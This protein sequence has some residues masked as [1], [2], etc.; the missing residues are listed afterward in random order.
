LHT[1]PLALKIDISGPS[2]VGKTS[3]ARRFAFECRQHF[4]LITVSCS[5]LVH[6]VVGDS[7]RR[8]SELFAAARKVA[9]TLI[10]LENIDIMLGNSSAKE[11][12][13]VA[14]NNDEKGDQGI[15]AEFTF[16]RSRTSDK[17][18]DRFLSAFL[19]EMDGI[20]SSSHSDK[21]GKIDS[22][23]FDSMLRALKP[24]VVIATSY[25]L[26]TL[27]ASL[28]R[29]GRLEE[30]LI[31]TTPDTATRQ[32]IISNCLDKIYFTDVVKGSIEYDNLLKFIVSSTEGW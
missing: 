7:E 1:I 15:N 8:I 9:P 25:D 30:H 17:T 4:K 16:P 21:A 22:A 5:D 24:V 26:E 12:K 13:A 31:L 32:A 29:P 3:L 10:L 14:R 6:K 20:L 19:I 28:L 11:E 27:D 2:G 18:I 23:N